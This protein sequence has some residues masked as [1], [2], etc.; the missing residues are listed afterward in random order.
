MG[1][2]T[3]VPIKGVEVVVGDF[4]MWSEPSQQCQ[5]TGPDFPVWKSLVSVGDSGCWET[6]RE[7]CP[8]PGSLKQNIS[9]RQAPSVFQCHQPTSLTIRA[10]SLQRLRAIQGAFLSP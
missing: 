1:R 9:N 5:L 7:D 2:Q 4:G 3:L 10:I 8:G 6:G